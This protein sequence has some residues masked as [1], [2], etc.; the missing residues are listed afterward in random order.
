MSRA[1]LADHSRGRGHSDDANPQRNAECLGSGPKLLCVM[2]AE[3][4]MDEMKWEL[5]TEL[6]GG[7]QAD[8]LKSFLEAEGIEVQLFQE[9]VGRHIYPVMVDGLARV[10][11]FVSKKQAREARQILKEFEK[12]NAGGA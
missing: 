10:Q 5:L 7:P 9:S 8:L 3:V 2:F 11:V 12:P 1:L 4:D 6:N